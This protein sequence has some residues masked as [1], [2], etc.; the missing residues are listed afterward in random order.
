MPKA[1]PLFNPNIEAV[2][3]GAEVDLYYLA[4]EL[5]KDKDFD[6]SFITADYGQQP[7]ETIEDVRIIK[8]LNFKENPLLG[9]IKIWRKLNEANSDIYVLKTASP[10]TPLTAL[11]CLLKHRFFVYRTASSRECN[12]LYLNEHFFSGRAFKWSLR[13][14]S[15]V[16][17]QNED[18]KKNLL[19]TT[20]VTSIVIPNAHRLTESPKT[21]RDIILWV[22]RSAPIKRPILFI[23]LAKQWPG[24]KFTFICQR[25]TGDEN[26]DE[27]V[28]RAKSVKNLE[29]IER[30]PFSE[31][32]DYFRRAKVFVNTSE[33]EGFPNTFI[34]ACKYAV[35]IL[36][37]NVNP[38]GFLDKYK[39]GICCNDDWERFVESLEFLLEENRNGQFGRR[40]IKY[41]EQKHDAA[42]IVE[43]YK[44]HFAGLGKKQQ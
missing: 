22:G 39:C 42:K 19:K 17:V 43:Q 24:E 44:Q 32:E 1:Y 26:Y 21:K 7:A 30:V 6:V 23:K 13:K 12:G 25:A 34:Q 41:V 8:S 38:D 40:A 18:D 5:A 4:T 35:P 29:F 28:A 10:G 37:L 11:F 16:F 27:L 36:S 3:G 33:S 9:A 31:V 14:A 2:F 20:A 15:I